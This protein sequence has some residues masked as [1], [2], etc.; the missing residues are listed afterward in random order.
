MLRT[1][2]VGKNN[3]ST[4]ERTVTFSL[5][6]VILFHKLELGNFQAAFPSVLGISWEEIHPPGRVNT[7]LENMENKFLL[8]ECLYDLSK[9][10]Y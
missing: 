3:H 8:L 10:R 7:M 6:E 2:F 4:K 1:C 5:N 9:D